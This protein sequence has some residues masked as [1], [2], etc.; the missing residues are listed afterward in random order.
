MPSRG[1]ATAILARRDFEQPRERNAWKRAFKLHIKPTASVFINC[2][3]DEEY[4]E[5]FDA[6]LFATVC[7]GFLPR[8][9]VDSGDVAEPRI[10]RILHGIYSSEYSIHDLSR[11]QGEG[12]LNLARFNMPLELGMAM[13]RRFAARQAKAFEEKHDHDWLALVPEEHQYARYIS[14]LAGFDPKR[15]DGSV[16]SIVQAVMAWLK[17]RGD[18][19]RTPSPPKVLSAFPNFHAQ[20]R[21]LTEEWG[22]EIPWLDIV[23]A[24]RDTAP[25]I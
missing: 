25:G 21:V 5:S 7:C 24:A 11:C 20:K 1:A 17:T 6:I 9:A 18:T 2:P 3:F 10:D 13:G 16:K 15:H 23:L 4:Q 12:E 19:I 14:D 22:N 8:S